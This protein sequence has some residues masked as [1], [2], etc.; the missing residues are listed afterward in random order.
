MMSK[1]H[2]TYKPKDR[3]GQL[4]GKHLAAEETDFPQ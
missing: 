1:L 2:A 3:P 4:T